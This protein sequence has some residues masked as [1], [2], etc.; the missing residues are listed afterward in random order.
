VTAQ[1]DQREAEIDELFQVPLN[2]F[3]ARRNALAKTLGGADATYIRKLTKPSVVAWAANQVYWQ[4]RSLYDRVIKSGERLRSAQ[5]A[6]LEG[7]R[8][9]VRSA[10]EAHRRAVGGAVAEAGRLAATAGSH[11]RPDA[12]MRTFE[13]ISLAAEAPEHPGRLT[14]AIQPAGFE[15]LLGVTPKPAPPGTRSGRERRP[16]TPAPRAREAAAP[17]A[18]EDRHAARERERR[19]AAEARRQTAKEK[20][21]QA[22]IRKGQAAIVRAKAIEARARAAWERA[23]EAVRKAEKELAAIQSER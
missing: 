11:P 7:K 10:S 4:A 3:T 2:E 18:S 8:A 5:I 15:A 23:Q 9:D 12:L 19:Q 21:R 6:A 17:R 14:E 16:E 13:A 20:K 1:D 22:A